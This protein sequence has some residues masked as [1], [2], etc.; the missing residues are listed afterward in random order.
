MCEDITPLSTNGRDF[1]VDPG[2]PQVGLWPDAVRSL[3]GSADALPRWTPSWE[4]RF[5]SL[6]GTNW[7]FE[8]QQ[9]PCSAIYLLGSRSSEAN[10]PRIEELTQRGAMLDLVQNTYMNW[11]LNPE[12]RAAEFD[13]LSKLV[14]HVPVR[15]IVPHAD[16]RR[17]G[18]L[19]E[20][21][22]KD[23]ERPIRRLASSVI[24]T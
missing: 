19:C 8:P 11:I 12:Q 22:E 10:T 16:S 2:Y 15:R 23:A 20:L 18:A 1:F 6:E 17:I 7:K 13:F 14:A 21:I 5:L 24:P 3:L 4:K 9:R